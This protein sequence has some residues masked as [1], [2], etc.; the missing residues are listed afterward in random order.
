MRLPLLGL[1]CK[2]RYPFLCVCYNCTVCPKHTRQPQEHAGNVLHLPTWCIALA[3]PDAGSL[4][5]TYFCGTVLAN[6]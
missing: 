1:R 2:V 6:S 5:H 3:V 4:R